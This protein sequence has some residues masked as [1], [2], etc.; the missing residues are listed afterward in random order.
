M[1][2]L[3]LAFASLIIGLVALYVVFIVYLFSRTTSFA[4]DDWKEVGRGSVSY[5]STN[6]VELSGD[7]KLQTGD[8][9]WLVQDGTNKYFNVHTVASDHITI[10]GGTDYT[11]TDSPIQAAYFSRSGNPYGFPELFNFDIGEVKANRFEG[12][13]VPAELVAKPAATYRLDGGEV[14]MFI[15]LQ[16]VAPSLGEYSYLRFDAPLDFIKDL[17]STRYDNPLVLFHSNSKLSPQP[18]EDATGMVNVGLFEANSLETSV[19][20]GRLDGPFVGGVMTGGAF[21]VSYRI[22]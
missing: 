13:D 9:L 16:A 20:I 7:F 8:S 22:N 5:N 15:N 14:T 3:P 18:L 17:N 12:G 2:K 1:Y 4:F 10:D 6:R 19:I 21:K 11:F